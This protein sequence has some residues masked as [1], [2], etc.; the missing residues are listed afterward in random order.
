MNQS[1][2]QDEDELA[3]FHFLV[4]FAG[5]FETMHFW[6]TECVSGCIVSL[7]TGTLLQTQHVDVFSLVTRDG[8]R[9]AM[10]R[11]RVHTH[12]QTDVGT[13]RCDY[14]RVVNMSV[15]TTDRVRELMLERQRVG[16]LERKPEGGIC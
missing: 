16:M 2:A 4:C 9:T 14:S 12:T 6:L 11:M 13:H 15:C 5:V 8:H 7:V 3:P 10:D 1:A